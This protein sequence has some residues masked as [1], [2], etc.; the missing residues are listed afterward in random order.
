MSFSAQMDLDD[1]PAQRKID[2]MK[3]AIQGFNLSFEQ[4]AQMGTSLAVALGET[5][6][7]ST[8]LGIQVARHFINLVTT[9]TAA[10]LASPAGKF[11]IGAKIGTIISLLAII[12]QLESGHTE[13]VQKTQAWVTL[14]SAWRY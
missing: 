5:V 4:I 12:Q 7:Q 10:Q 1:S 9:T 6:S 3:R 14:F 8:Q 11:L 2:R 13:S